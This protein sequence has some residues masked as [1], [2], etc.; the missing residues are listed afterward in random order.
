MGKP[1]TNREIFEAGRMKRGTLGPTVQQRRSATLATEARQLRDAGCTVV[2]IARRL[3]V[4]E[5]QVQRYVK[6]TP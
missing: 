5:R 1:M 2:Y 3:G 4:S 6:A